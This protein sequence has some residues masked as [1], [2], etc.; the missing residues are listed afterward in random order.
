MG[1]AP[2]AV[3]DMSPRSFHGRKGV[4]KLCCPEGATGNS[5]MAA[6]KIED[7]GWSDFC[8]TRYK[9]LK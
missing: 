1:G 2:S 6:C 8:V 7:Q 9:S 4:R 3:R 5:K